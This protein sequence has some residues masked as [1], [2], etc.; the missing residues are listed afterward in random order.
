MSVSSKKRAEVGEKLQYLVHEYNDNTIRFVLLYN[1]M[2]DKDILCQST[3]RVVES[4]DI[5]HSSFGTDSMSAYWCV[6]EINDVNS[7]FSY[8]FTEKNPLDIAIKYA[9]EPVASDSVAQ[10]RCT[11]VQSKDTSV[12]VLNISHLCVDGCDGK[13]LLHKLI[14]IYNSINVSNG[15]EKCVIKNGSRKPQ[16]VYDTLTKKE[17]WSL[18]K[19]PMSKVR[20]NFPY[21]TKEPGEKNL[22]YAIISKQIIENAYKKAKSQNATINDVMLAACY[23][24]YAQ[25]PQ[26]DNNEVMGITSMMDLRKY[27]KSGDSQGLSNIT[28]LLA[29]SLAEGVKEDFADTLEEVEKQTRHIKADPLAGLYGMPLLHN[30]VSTIPMGLLQKI[31]GSFYGS[32]SM[33]LTNLGNLDS[34][35]LEMGGLIPNLAIFGGPLK[36]KPGMQV[37]VLS[38]DNECVLSIIGQWTDN[39]EKVLRKFLDNMVEGITDY[40]T[41]G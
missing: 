30:A 18:M 13:Y 14:E 10:L 36:Q 16:Q 5:L 26:V 41:K 7:F 1:G 34:K 22:I 6:N 31:A 28:G 38:L 32:F 21:P 35:L 24:A 9:I 2:V 33:G 3:K 19:N 37:S 40:A 23:H 17:Y 15:G 12:I 39:D 4:V 11:L 27:C 20:I 25:L 8:E 29:T